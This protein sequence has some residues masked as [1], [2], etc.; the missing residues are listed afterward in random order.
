M[1]IFFEKDRKSTTWMKKSLLLLFACLSLLIVPTAT[2]AQT[3]SPSTAQTQK[4]A[5]APGF[6]GPKG[7]VLGLADIIAAIFNNIFSLFLGAGNAEPPPLNCIDAVTVLQHVRRDFTENLKRPLGAVDCTKK[8][9]HL[10][11]YQGEFRETLSTTF[12]FP[13]P[14]E[15]LIR[16]LTGTAHLKLKSVA[17]LPGLQLS[18]E[19]LQNLSS[20]WEKQEQTGQTALGNYAR[21][22]FSC[23]IQNH[24]NGVVDKA[25]VIA[26]T[27]A[28]AKL[29]PVKL[30]SPL[31][32]EWINS[33]L[34]EAEVTI[35]D[36][37]IGYACKFLL[38]EQGN[39]QPKFCNK[40][41]Q[42]DYPVA[43]VTD[44]GQIICSDEGDNR[45]LMVSDFA[46]SNK[47]FKVPGL[48]SPDQADILCE[49]LYG[50]QYRQ[51]ITTSTSVL[52][53]FFGGD[54]SIKRPD[55]SQ[56]YPPGT[57]WRY[58]P[59]VNQS[60]ALYTYEE[61]VHGEVQDP[62]YNN[63][64][65][66]FKATLPVYAIRDMA[67]SLSK[68]FGVYK[69][70][71]DEE[72]SPPDCGTDCIKSAE[73]VS[74]GSGD[75]SQFNYG[76]GDYADNP[77]GRQQ[78]V[79]GETSENQL[80]A[81]AQLPPEDV[82]PADPTPIPDPEEVT[83]E[84]V[85]PTT[86]K[87]EVTQPFADAH[88]YTVGIG[89]GAVNNFMNIAQKAAL[90]KE[91]NGTKLKSVPGPLILDISGQSVRNNLKGF[92]GTGGWS[93]AL[94]QCGYLNRTIIYPVGYAEKYCEGQDTSDNFD[95]WFAQKIVEVNLARKVDDMFA[96][97]A[98]F[99]NASNKKDS[100][101]QSN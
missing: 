1:T 71:P 75:E 12:N 47:N 17:L 19:F 40:E 13:W 77:H 68:Y 38:D 62:S 83:I 86:I 30:K 16:L 18:A 58:I 23:Q 94:H 98:S 72:I 34:A 50:P 93:A 59:T 25:T 99:K 76:F 43:F 74:A 20:Y 69:E 24:I 79:L 21:P 29:R 80:L 57:A 96:Q 2:L 39:P 9:T 41:W 7:E 28:L 48:I 46:C 85:R 36:V 81:Q 60:D 91:I 44:Q 67:M 27:G 51:G 90:E 6:S 84:I 63:N 22:V 31:N 73:Q 42:A 101:S 66:T 5:S 32:E 26:E 10:V 82:P 100:L 95:R 45:E 35:R 53:D 8:P 4:A 49:I 87:V 55:F 52:G 37:M 33:G 70:L 78:N 65:Y 92:P 56:L 88:N 14:I 97:L 15:E 11:T 54:A 61:T 89:D 64:K 3:A